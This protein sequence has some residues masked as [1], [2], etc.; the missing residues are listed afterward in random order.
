M[1]KIK[2]LLLGMLA[3]LI[4]ACD[5][6]DS[7]SE[8]LAFTETE[9]SEAPVW[10]MDWTNNQEKPNWTEPDE[11]VYENSTILKVQIDK[12]LKPYASEGDMLAIFV[13]GELRG[14]TTPVQTLSG[15]KELGKFLLKVWGNESGTETVNMSLSYY[16]QTLKHIFTLSDNINLDSDVTTGIDEDFIP[17][18]IYGSAKYPVVMPFNA[19]TLLALADIKPAAGD[20]LAAFVGEECRGICP[21]VTDAL[22]LTIFG[23][24]AGESIT[25]KYYQAATGKLYTFENAVQ[26]K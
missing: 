8:E 23:R 9:V 21:S 2:Y 4:W 20:H 17:E 15:Q 19:T 16:S 10:Q 11:S 13:N 3:V 5:S 22:S 25:I 7:D 1:N 14:M 24:T 6:S 18:F 12:T 26:V